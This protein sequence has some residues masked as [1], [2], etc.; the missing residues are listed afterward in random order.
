MPRPRRAS[1]LAQPAER[2]PAEAG[3]AFQ[4]PGMV[5]ARATPGAPATP[6]GRSPGIRQVGTKRLNGALA[7][8]HVVLGQEACGQTSGSNGKGP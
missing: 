4:V 6:L 1:G 3:D 7:A 8:G 5:T 2:Q